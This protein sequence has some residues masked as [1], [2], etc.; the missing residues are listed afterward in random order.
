MCDLVNGFFEICGGAF[1]M[2]SIVKLHGE[3]KVRGVSLIHATFFFLWGVWNLFYYPYLGQ[4]L[5][6]VGSLAVTGTNL[7]WAT[8]LLHYTMK[9]RRSE[10]T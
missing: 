1:V 6:F 9:E 7:V 2:L 4:W 5:S 3:K 8:M 10:V